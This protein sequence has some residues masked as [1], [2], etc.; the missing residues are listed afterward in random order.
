[1]IFDGNYRPNLWPGQLVTRQVYE[2][3]YRLTDIA[4]PT[5]EDERQVFGDVDKNAIMERLQSW[6]V[7]EIVL[8]MGELG[9]L[10][11]TAHER[12]SVAANK[13]AVVDTTSAGDSF[14]A[15]YLAARLRGQS[16]SEA[17]KVG[18]RLASVVIRHRGAIIPVTAMPSEQ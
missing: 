13:V 15:G 1:M 2:A 16:A 7:S 6:G 11:M 17:A 18:H 3:M 12:E 5:I 9:C 4:L 14:N 8:K 10:V